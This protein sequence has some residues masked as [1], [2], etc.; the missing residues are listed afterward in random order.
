ML[1]AA[2][3]WFACITGLSAQITP[4][5]ALKNFKLPKYNENSYR[6]Y[7][8]SGVEGIYD[9]S[10]FF[11]VTQADLSIYSGDEQQILQTQITADH[12]NFDLNN[13]TAYGDSVI[14]IRD[15]DFYIR[16]KEWK[17]DMENKRITIEREGMMHFYQDLKL[18]LSEIF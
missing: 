10:G 16:G 4:H 6:A 7:T 2:P 9:K 18:D 11:T 14:E 8:L 17:L 15:E 13:D 1:L 3:L 5:S 12:A